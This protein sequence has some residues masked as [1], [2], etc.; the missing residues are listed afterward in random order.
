MIVA[1]ILVFGLGDM[2][3]GLGE[4]QLAGIGLADVVGVLLN[5]IIPV[6]KK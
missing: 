6:N 5:R 1:V 2:A 3:L 4:F